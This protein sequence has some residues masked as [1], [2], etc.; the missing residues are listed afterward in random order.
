MKVIFIGSGNLATQLGLALQS[1]GIIISQ[2][3]SRT[4]ANAKLLAELLNADYTNEISE[5]Y[6]DADIYIY[7]LKDSFL[8]NFL[9]RFEFPQDAIHI[10]TAGSIQMNDFSGFAYKYGVFYPLQTFSKNKSVDF[11]EIPI[12]IEASDDEVKQELMKLGYSLTQKV[13]I[14][15]SEQRKQLHLA[16]VFAC[17]FSNYMYD[18]AAEIVGKAGIGFDI[19]QPLITETA[20][21]IKTLN[22]YE[23]QTGPAVRYDK[24]TIRTHLSM[25]SRMPELKSIYEELSTN[26]HK[27]HKSNTAKVNSMERIIKK[28]YRF[29]VSKQKK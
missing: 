21:K 22:P 16:A 10:H 9:N 15:N 25:L 3:Y 6:Q 24:K 11:S 17:N 28:T 8:I 19:L 2:I 12:C 4:K 29:L 23:A 7:A 26:I 13:Y 1:K 18:I 27:R 14:V 5:I 20:N